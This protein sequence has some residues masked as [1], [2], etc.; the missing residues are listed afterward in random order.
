MGYDN[1]VHLV[2]DEEE[3]RVRKDNAGLIIVFVNI[4][5]SPKDKV[6]GIETHVVCICIL[7]YCES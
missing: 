1:E 2:G 3:R 7:K 6:V 4:Y 5:C